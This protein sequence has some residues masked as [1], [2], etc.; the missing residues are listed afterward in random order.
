MGPG[1]SRIKPSTINEV[2]MNIF[3]L[4]KVH[5]TMIMIAIASLSLLIVIGN[6][7]V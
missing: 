1:G 5:D 2:V 6:M 7:G 4:G 3:G